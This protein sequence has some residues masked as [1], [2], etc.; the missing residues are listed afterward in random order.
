MSEHRFNPWPL[1]PVKMANQKRYA[2]R[3]E[4][5][6]ERY[7]QN[8]EE[9]LRKANAYHARKRAMNRPTST[10]IE[11]SRILCV[12]L[13]IFGEPELSHDDSAQ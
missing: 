8:R 13:T 4:Y 9:L 6:K 12:L 5:F 10:R 7:Q 3:K 1:D 2:M 11:A